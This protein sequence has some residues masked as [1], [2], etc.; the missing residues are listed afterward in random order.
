MKATEIQTNGNNF[1]R[2]ISLALFGFK[3][4]GNMR[5]PFSLCQKNHLGIFAVVRI[6]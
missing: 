1:H 2:D 4:Y 5:Y 3:E 6:I